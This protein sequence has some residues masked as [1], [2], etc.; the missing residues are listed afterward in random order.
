MAPPIS[1]HIIIFSL[2]WVWPHFSV[3]KSCLQFASILCVCMIFTSEQE[4]MS[5]L[6]NYNW[7]LRG[8]GALILS[9]W[10]LF[11]RLPRWDLHRFQGT[12]VWLNHWYPLRDFSWYYFL[13]WLLLIL[14]Y[15]LLLY[16]IFLGTKLLTYKS[17]SLGWLPGSPA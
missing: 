7:S 16:Y 13:A 6:A 5:Q 10:L 12:L 4:F 3:L 14:F 8:E 2:I 15:F 11:G 17:P 9:L 1:F